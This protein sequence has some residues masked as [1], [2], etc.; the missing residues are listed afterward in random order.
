MNHSPYRWIYQKTPQHVT[1][2]DGK[3]GTTK[4]QRGVRR[5]TKLHPIRTGSMCVWI[6]WWWWSQFEYSTDS[7]PY[8]HTH[9]YIIIIHQCDPLIDGRLYDDNSNNMRTSTTTHHHNTLLIYIYT[10]FLCDAYNAIFLSEIV[11]LS[12][13]ESV[14]ANV[15]RALCVVCLWYIYEALRVEHYSVHAWLGCSHGWMGRCRCV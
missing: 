3:C 8:T 9:I 13:S 11:R 1:G 5:L 10:N 12:V 4:N 6:P 14:E 15:A 7:L 2:N